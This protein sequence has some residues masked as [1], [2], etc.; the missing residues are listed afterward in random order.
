MLLFLDG[1]SDDS[2]NVTQPPIATMYMAGEGVPKDTL[3]AIEYFEKCLHMGKP[4]Y[5]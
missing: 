3:T 5:A 4:Q 1:I 2:V